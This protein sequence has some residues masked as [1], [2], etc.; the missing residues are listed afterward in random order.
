MEEH[1]QDQLRAATA[2]WI[3]KTAS[4]LELNRQQP[5]MKVEEDWE[6]VKNL[7]QSRSQNGNKLWEGI[8]EGCRE[9]RSFGAEGEIYLEA[10]S[11]YQ[12]MT[13]LFLFILGSPYNWLL[14]NH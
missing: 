5:G 12:A 13:A 6:Q 9:E 14:N 7:E 10:V 3:Q 1:R 4:A 8:K 11:P 2:N